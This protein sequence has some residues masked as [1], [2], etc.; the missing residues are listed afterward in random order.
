MV[1]HLLPLMKCNMNRLLKFIIILFLSK[2][3]YSMSVQKNHLN[4]VAANGHLSVKGNSL[5]NQSG[6]NIQLKG[7]SSFWLNWHGE[8]SNASSIKSLKDNW[9]ISIFRAAMGVEEEFG[10]LENPLEMVKKVEEIIQI[11]IKE[12]IYI[13][14]DYHAHAANQNI[15]EA[16]KFFSYISKKYGTYPNIIYEVWN[17]PL[18]ISWEDEIRPYMIELIKTIRANDK[19]NIILLGT[20]YWCQRVD[21][22]YKNPI[23]EK[24]I[25]Y[26]AHFY[27]GTHKE[28]L[29][30]NLDE[31]WKAGCPIFISEFG[32]SIYDGGTLDKNVYL[33]EADLW[34]DWMKKRKISWLTWSLCDK[35]ESS[36]LL[37]P[38]ASIYGNWN[39]DEL[40]KAGKFIKNKINNN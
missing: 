37:N 2:A 30:N 12:N 13:I 29:R 33:E 26:T 35:D 16:K 11:C 17:E 38:G 39:E 27:T 3:S 9:G 8:F 28:K 22:A 32:V 5:I 21:E 7:V 14:V 34:I 6:D 19:D 1:K 23:D 18:K 25:M 36:A 24:N 15:K 31:L 4:S 40:S 20:P 10:Y